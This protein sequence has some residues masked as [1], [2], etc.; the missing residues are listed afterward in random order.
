MMDLC[1]IS[2]TGKEKYAEL[3]DSC[4]GLAGVLQSIPSCQPSLAMLLAL[5]PVMKP[6]SY[7]VASV[8]TDL[9]IVFTIFQKGSSGLFGAC[10]SW[11]QRLAQLD[12]AFLADRKKG[13]ACISKKKVGCLFHVSLKTNGLI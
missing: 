6:R 2:A 11:L 5:L 12:G 4:Q 10:T 13:L 9:E 3:S 7:S 1:E 8:G